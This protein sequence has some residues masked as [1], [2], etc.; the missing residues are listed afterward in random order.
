MIVGGASNEVQAAGSFVGGGR[1]NRVGGSDGAIDC[2]I[3]GGR[4]NEARGVVSAVG[5]GLNNRAVGDYSAVPG[6]NGCGALGKG[7][8]AAGTIATAHNDGSF[9]W[10]DGSGGPTADSGPNQFVVGASGGAWVWSDPARTLGVLLSPGGTA[11]ATPCAA[12]GR[13]DLTRLDPAATLA[14][15]EGLPIY[16][17]GNGGAKCRG[18]TAEDWHRLF[19]S[20]GK[21]PRAIDTMDLDGVALAAI[22]GLLDLVRRQEAALGAQAARLAALEQKSGAR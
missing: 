8:F 10:G 11:W 16:E 4:G 7:S 19:P 6:G 21:D 2:V 3:V 18:P 20:P 13:G 9:V 5:G 1:G 15:V 17:Y 14:Q 12:G 22:K